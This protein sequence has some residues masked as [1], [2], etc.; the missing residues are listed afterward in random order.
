MK[1]L[2]CGSSAQSPECIPALYTSQLLLA[3]GAQHSDLLK[4]AVA[5]AAAQVNAAAAPILAG[6][7][8]GLGSSVAVAHVAG[9][10]AE[11][12]GGG[13]SALPKPVPLDE[14]VVMVVAQYLY[15]QLRDFIRWLMRCLGRIV[16]RRHHDT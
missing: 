8:E 13:P 4:Q 10:G 14:A 16:F 15:Q 12:P 5:G 1:P 9:G 2:S 11:Q 6:G 7:E 3:S